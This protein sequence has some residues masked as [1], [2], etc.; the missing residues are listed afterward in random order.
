LSIAR[1]LVIYIPMAMIVSH[2]FGYIGIFVA[3]ALTNI[4]V[5][6][7]AVVWNRKVLMEEK[8]RLTGPG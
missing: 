3:T 8:A 5:G 1:L 6:I 7:A 4:L 2:Y